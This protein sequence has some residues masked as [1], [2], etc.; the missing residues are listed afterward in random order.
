MVSWTAVITGYAQRECGKEALELF[1]EM[2]KV[3]IGL[4]QV[5]LASVLSSCAVLA[6]VEQGKQ[7]MRDVEE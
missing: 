6:V 2:R 3:D 1:L 5:T 4:D 7:G